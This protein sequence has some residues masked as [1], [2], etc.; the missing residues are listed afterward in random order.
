MIS[1]IVPVYNEKNTILKILKKIDDVKNVKKEIIIVDDCSNDG[2]R[3][4]LKKL[5]NSNYKIY[6]H[7][8]NQGKGAAIKT[9]KKYIEGE[10]I[11]IQ[12]ADLE[13]DPQDYIKLIDPILKK[14]VSVVY[15]SRV[16]GKNRYLIKNFSSVYRIFFNHFLTVTSNI[17]NNQNLTDAHT[18]YK[19]FTKD[20]F[21][22]ID[23]LENDFS[24]CPEIT[25]KISLKNIKIKEV[26][27]EYYGRSYKEGKKIKLIDGVKALLTLVKYR[28]LK[29]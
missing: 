24:F 20:L 10:I 5:N 23:L 12:D 1:I 14:E 29:K 15:G 6:F 9:A 22:S 18:C 3:E 7:Q 8:K 27:I 13:Y 4:I 25:T 26:P 19:T 17:I 16:L 28:F 21:L 11:I 2:T